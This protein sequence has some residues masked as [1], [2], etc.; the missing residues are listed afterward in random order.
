[1]SF[2]ERKEG[3]DCIP[4]IIIVPFFLR[5]FFSSASSLS[6]SRVFGS[7]DMLF[8]GFDERLH[9]I[10]LIGMLFDVIPAMPPTSEEDDSRAS[11]TNV[12]P[13]ML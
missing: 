10:C 2:I 13:S 7:Q 6:I 11:R 5:S 8:F 4:R 3:K 12:E 1:M 9:E